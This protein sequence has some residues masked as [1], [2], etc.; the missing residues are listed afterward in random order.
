MGQVRLGEMNRLKVIKMLDFGVYLQASLDEILVPTRYVPE[1]IQIG[2]YLDVFVYRD[3]E[4]RIIATTL[5]PF[6]ELGGFANLEVVDVNRYGVFMDWGLP[7]NLFVPFSEQNGRMV[8]G[9]KY[10]VTCYIDNETDRIIGTARIERH[11]DPITDRLT[12]NQKVSII[13]FKYTDL[14]IKCIV[15]GRY[16]GMLF[17]NSL[18]GKLFLGNEY[19]AYIQTI[20]PDGKIDLNQKNTTEGFDAHMKQ[21]MRALEAANGKLPYNDK[22]SS[23][24]IFEVFGISKRDFK[25]S[26]GRLYKADKIIILPAGIEKK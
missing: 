26:I 10:V 2:D 3:S 15:N 25:Q 6:L 19:T 8:V 23:E 14:G 12:V 4:D 20:R 21:I 24:L 16:E 5:K 9:N 1:D 13:P 22:T 17:K 7:K 11:L 18:L